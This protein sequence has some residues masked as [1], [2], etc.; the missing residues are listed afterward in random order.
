MCPCAFERMLLTDSSLGFSCNRIFAS[1]VFY[2]R[3]LIRA[4]FSRFLSFASLPLHLS[5]LSVT[6]SNHLG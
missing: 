3:P 1:R 6:A 5:T 4:H 2:W